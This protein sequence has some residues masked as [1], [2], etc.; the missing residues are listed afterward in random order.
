[1][2]VIING[3]QHELPDELTQPAIHAL[4][5]AGITRVSDLAR[6]RKSEILQ[7]LG[8]GPKSIGPLEDLK[9]PVILGN[10]VCLHPVPDVQT[11]LMLTESRQLHTGSVLCCYLVE[12][13]VESK[14][15]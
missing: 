7:L 15:A 4:S 9:D 13:R 14:A 1:M 5:G 3:A 12:D 2:P 10:G 6:F 11:T 8:I